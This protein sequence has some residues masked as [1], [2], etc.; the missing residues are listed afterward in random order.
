MSAP[1]FRERPAA[2]EASGL[3]VLHHGRGTDEHD[4][5]P[6]AD[7]LDPRK[8]LHVVTPRAPLTLPGWAGHH[9]Y[10][11]PR[12]GYPDRD[13]PADIK[14]RLP[15]SAVLHREQYSAAAQSD[16]FAAYDA[17]IRAAL[18]ILGFPLR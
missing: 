11:V 12:V 5:L 8:R 3:L 2:G 6:L 7:A 15:Q 4:L 9:W 13:K 17:R 1:V 10:V 16:A 18:E 14:P